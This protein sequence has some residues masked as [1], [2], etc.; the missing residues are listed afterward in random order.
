MYDGM[1]DAHI[2]FDLSKTDNIAPDVGQVNERNI[3]CNFCS[4]VLIWQGGAIKCQHNVSN[5]EKKCD[6]SLLIQVDLIKNNLRE[7]EPMNAYWHVNDLSHF[8]NIMIH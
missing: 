2:N 4:N 7:F 6:N 3:I 1:T 8:N 5:Q